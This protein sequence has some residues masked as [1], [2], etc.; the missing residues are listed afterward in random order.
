VKHQTVTCPFCFQE[1]RTGHA[2]GRECLAALDRAVTR[3]QKQAAKAAA[4]ESS[5]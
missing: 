5:E 3:D 4:K 2:S 1:T